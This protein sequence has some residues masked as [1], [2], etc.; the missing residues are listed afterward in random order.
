MTAY[1]DFVKSKWSSVQG[2]SQE[3]M[4]AIGAMWRQQ[5]G[6]RLAGAGAKTAKTPA[7]RDM[8]EQIA[9]LENDDIPDQAPVNTGL[10]GGGRKRIR[11]GGL[12]AFARMDPLGSSS[13]IVGM[14]CQ[15]CDHNI[16]GEG[17]FGDLLGGIIGLTGL[18][19]DGEDEDTERSITGGRA[20][21]NETL[22]AVGG[23]AGNVLGAIPAIVSGNPIGAIQ[24]IAK[25]FGSIFNLF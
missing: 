6:G 14:G 3:K 2:T 5:K 4:K 22:S 18:G 10:R 21:L 16:S 12:D 15:S 13:S 9:M 19:M 23:L 11:G 25:S 7:T 17:M 20:D 1:N 8:D 24:N